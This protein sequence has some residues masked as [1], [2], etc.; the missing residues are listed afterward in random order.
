[1]VNGSGLGAVA[2]LG[3]A[4][5]HDEVLGNHGGGSN[6]GFIR[7]IA[8]GG[9]ALPNDGIQPPTLGTVQQSRASGTAQPGA[10]VRLFTEEDLGGGLTKLSPLLA[11]TKTNSQGQ[12]SGTYGTQPVGTRIVAT[13]TL[14]GGTSEV[15]APVPAE[16]DRPEP[17]KGEENPPVVTPPAPALAPKITG[18]PGKL[19]SS[20]TAKFQ[21]VARTP[22]STSNADSTA[23]T[24]PTAPRRRPTGTCSPVSTRSVSVRS[25]RRP[26]RGD[27]VPV[28][29][30][31]VG[32]SKLMGRKPA[33]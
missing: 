4:A 18:R 25:C 8:L 3:G 15:S 23:A 22:G 24:G 17:P 13:Q 26:R 20:R 11:T 6:G 12:W 33:I 28:P 16:V 19:T 9:S 14:N 2:I 10:T 31:T 7:L 30:Q 27:E 5:D 32:T 21:F 29:H 1:M